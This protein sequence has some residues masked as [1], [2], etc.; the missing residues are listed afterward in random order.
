MISRACYVVCDVCHS[1][2]EISTNGA[3]EARDFARRQGFVRT[4]RHDYCP[5]H[6]PGVKPAAAAQE[7]DR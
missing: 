1:P 3:P 5:E 2:A 4:G 6:A 7:T